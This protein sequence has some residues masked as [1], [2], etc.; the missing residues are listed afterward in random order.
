V[1]APAEIKG[2]I[3]E[4][5][6]DDGPWGARGV[7]EHTMVPTAP[8]IANAVYDALGVRITSLPLTAEKVYLA[9]QEK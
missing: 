1:D 3:V 2:H 7:G 5:P 4:V 6:Q 9:L 8:A